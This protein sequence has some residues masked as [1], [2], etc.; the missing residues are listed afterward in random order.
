M[1]VTP[2]VAEAADAIRAMIASGTLKPGDQGPTSAMLHEATGISVYRCL[3]GLRLLVAEGVLFQRE[4]RGTRWI[5]ADRA[6]PASGGGPMNVPRPG[7][8]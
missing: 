3:L 4:S 2:V 6:Q 1:K 7:R 5:V 8:A